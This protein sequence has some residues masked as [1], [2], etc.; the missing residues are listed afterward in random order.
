ML[1]RFDFWTAVVGEVLSWVAMAAFGIVIYRTY[2]E[3][4]HAR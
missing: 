2:Q 4:R 3:E 1:A